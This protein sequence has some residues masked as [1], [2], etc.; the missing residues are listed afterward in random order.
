LL[1]SNLFKFQTQR[2]GDDSLNQINTSLLRSSGPILVTGHT[3]F[4]GAW[5]LHLLRHLGI[6]AI[7]YSLPPEPDC[8]YQRCNL[9]GQ[10]PEHFGD[11]RNYT[12][13]EKFI[14]F[15]QPAGVIHLAAQAL[16]MNSYTNPRETFEVNVIGTT[17][18]LSAA[19][20][21]E[22]VKGIVVATTDK[23]YRNNNSGRS[24]IETDP[25]E[26]KD[27]YSASKVGT[28]A[29]VS[30]WQQIK[31]I[32]GGPSLISVRAGNVIGGGDWG[33]NR[34]LPDLVR[35][36]MSGSE[37]LIRNPESTR[38][39]QHVLDPVTGYVMALGKLLAGEELSSINFGPDGPNLSVAQV[40][41]L[42]SREWSSSSARIVFGQN[43]MSD[44]KEA[45]YLNLNAEL[46]NKLLGWNPV[47]DQESSV[48]DTV[49]WWKSILG[50]EVQIQEAIKKDL[51]NL[52]LS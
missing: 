52:K 13:L 20:A 39:W 45:I 19:F 48:V 40:A 27:P 38:P 29:A 30:A 44:T 17:N 23:V 2:A 49:K 12:A 51:N 16:V 7:G 1:E 9:E 6:P 25:L 47:W 8:L 36:F 15:H 33:L 10:V 31:K 42:A 46:A 50:G 4:K 3:G 21:C 14:N 34:L 22:S 26:G 28:E 5:L 35:G 11:I 41:E 18:V 32:S 24:F 43:S 37:I